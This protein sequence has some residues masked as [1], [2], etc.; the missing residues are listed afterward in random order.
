MVL[1][2]NNCADTF[3]LGQSYTLYWYTLLVFTDADTFRL[4][5]LYSISILYFGG[6]DSADMDT[7]RLGQ[8]ITLSAYFDGLDASDVDTSRLGQSYTLLV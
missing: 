6:L 5:Q 1:G 3:R 4:E 2:W 7:F 8:S